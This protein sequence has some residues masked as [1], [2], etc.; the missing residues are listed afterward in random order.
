MKSMYRS[1]WVKLSL[2]ERFIWSFD[3]PCFAVARTAAIFSGLQLGLKEPK[4]D[5]SH[6]LNRSAIVLWEWSTA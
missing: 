5:G 1:I 2:A 3:A 4:Y 6:V